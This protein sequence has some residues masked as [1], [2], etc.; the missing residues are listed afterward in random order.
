MPEDTD[1]KLPRWSHSADG[2]PQL[3]PQAIDYA[4]GDLVLDREDVGQLPV[5]TAGP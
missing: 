1:R 5:I 3:Q 2:L 4:A